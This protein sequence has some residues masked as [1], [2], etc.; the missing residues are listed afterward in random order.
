[1]RGKGKNRA[2]A[3]AGALL[4]AFGLWSLR[5]W[6]GAQGVWQVLPYACIGLGCGA[7]GQGMGALLSARALKNCP[8]A[9]ER[10]QIETEDERNQA[11]GNRA[12]A[13]AFD[14]MVYLFGALLVAFA[15]MGVEPAAVLLLVAAYLF[16]MGYGAYCRVKYEKEM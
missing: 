16:V 12:K 11:I 3:A 1:M 5:G 15:L 8:Q 4:A 6:A 7:F 9:A 10:L 14:L 13:R 2:L